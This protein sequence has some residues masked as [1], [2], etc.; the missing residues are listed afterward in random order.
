[1][2]G[3]PVARYIVLACKEHHPELSASD[4]AK[5]L[6]ISR[7]RVSQILHKPLRAYAP[8]KAGA[9]KEEVCS[10]TR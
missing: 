5:L 8:K 1:M 9:A 3:Q 7:Q 2:K 10:E 6:G 4:I